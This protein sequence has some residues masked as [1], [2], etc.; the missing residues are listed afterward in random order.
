LS[1]SMDIQVAS[2]FERYLYYRVD[3]DAE[4]L[5]GLMAGFARSRS[6]EVSGNF[7]E[8]HDHAIVAGV[9]DTGA[10]LSAIRRYHE[11]YGY[12]LDPHT[13]VG[14]HV[15]E[16]FQRDDEPTICL[17]TAHGAK[18]SDAIRR[19]TGEPARHEIL[20][21]LLEAPARCESVPNDRQ[22]VCDYIAGHASQGPIRR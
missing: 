13:A 19:A 9:A 4:K 2:N 3:E 17:A 1:P 6:L 20:E 11:E 21:G 5:R 10:T 22:A 7:G 12:L 18:F 8:S 16:S 14:V 15:A